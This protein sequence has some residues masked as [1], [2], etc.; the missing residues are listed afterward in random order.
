MQKRGSEKLKGRRY[1]VELGAQ[2]WRWY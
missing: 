1:L 2:I